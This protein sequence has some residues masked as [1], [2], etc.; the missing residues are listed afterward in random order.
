MV[1]SADF[2]QN[3]IVFA[4]VGYAIAFAFQVYMMWLNIKQSRVNN[5][6][7]ELISEVKKLR[8]AMEA[9]HKIPKKKK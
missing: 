2:L 5:Q 6:M 4:L 8:T 9:K 3:S 7:D 1:L